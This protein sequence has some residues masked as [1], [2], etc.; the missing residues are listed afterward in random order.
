MLLLTL[1]KFL[2]SLVE[3]KPD[4]YLDELQVALRNGLQAETSMAT[5]CRELK[6]HG[7][8]RKK[9]C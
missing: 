8:T 4:L 1:L 7:L 5:I 6:R 2:D 9:V 3:Q